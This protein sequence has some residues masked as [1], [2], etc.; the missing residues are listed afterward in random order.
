M[1]R[2][3]KDN[4]FSVDWPVGSSGW[5][6]FNYGIDWYSVEEATGPQSMI[7]SYQIKIKTDV[8]APHCYFFDETGDCYSLNVE[9]PGEHIVRYNSD[10]PKI[11]KVRIGDQK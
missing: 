8:W 11:V 10:K 2:A 9:L 7:Y 3:A 6:G 1:P 4:E 5:P